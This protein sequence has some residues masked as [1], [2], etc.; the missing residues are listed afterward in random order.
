MSARAWLVVVALAGC[1]PRTALEAPAGGT[2]PWLRE[3]TSC[4]ACHDRIATLAGED[5]SFGSLWQASIMANSAR[6][7]YW[8]AA[9]RREVID[10]APVGAVIEDECARCHMPMGSERARAAGHRAEVFANLPGVRGADPLAIDGVACS[11]CHQITAARLGERASF[12]G[13]FV[14]AANAWPAIYGP[15]ELPP[16]Q[17]S[18]MRST[19]GVLP[20]RGDHVR[21]SELCATCHTLYTK[22]RDAQHR[23]IGEFPEQVPYLEWLQSAYKDTQSCQACHMPTVD[24]PTALTAVAGIPRDGLARHDFR[25]AN[26][27]TLG[28][29]DRH[30][31]ELGVAAPGPT[32]E[33]A[34]ATTRTFL[35]HAS[36][37]VAIASPSRDGA[38]LT[39]DI[40]V[41]NLGGHKLPTAYPSR[42]VWLHVTV[43]DATGAVRFESGKLLPTGA[44]DG[45]PNDLDPRRFEPHH[46]MIRAPGEVQIYEAILGDPQGQVTTALLSTSQYLK[47][48]RLLPRGFVKATASADTAVHGNALADPDFADGRDRVRYAVDVGDAPGPLAIDVE[49]MYQ[50]VGYRWAHN[51]EPYAAAEPQRYVDYY[52]EMARASAIVLARATQQV[53]AG[54]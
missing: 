29:L 42:R 34:M 14:I 26:F 10:H 31:A 2:T 38:A 13:G 1:Q 47:D 27:L 50:P 39:A 17:T 18:L 11:L 51:L 37:R 48:N 5:V 49:L 36:A 46:A 54:R 53:P 35:E 19:L 30:R 3:G 9:V 16:A 7:P 21:R 22:T 52:D 45:N 43:R 23:E 32:L 41:E 33:A 15:Y 24:V 6:D 20:V 8:Q 4:M 40:D 25:G 12:T 44:I 28:M